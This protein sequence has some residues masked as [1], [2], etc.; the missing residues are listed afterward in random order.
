[1]KISVGPSL[2]SRKNTHVSMW[3]IIRMII[4][5]RLEELT[6]LKVTSPSL[7]ILNEL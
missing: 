7:E 5:I 6:C 1:M 2:P 4:I 3:R